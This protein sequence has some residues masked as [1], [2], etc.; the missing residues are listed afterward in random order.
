MLQHNLHT[1]FYEP[2]LTHRVDYKILYNVL[3]KKAFYQERDQDQD[4]AL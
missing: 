4:P 1:S 2:L 3:N